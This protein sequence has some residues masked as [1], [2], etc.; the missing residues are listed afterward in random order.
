GVARA[1]RRR[2]SGS[3]RAAAHSFAASSAPGHCAWPGE[4]ARRIADLCRAEPFARP[5]EGPSESQHAAALRAFARGQ[6]QRRAL[7]FSGGPGPGNPSLSG[8][9]IT[10][11]AGDGSQ[12]G[13]ELHAGHFFV[14]Q[15]IGWVARSRPPVCHPK[16]EPRMKEH[17]FEDLSNLSMLDLFRIEAESQTGILTTSLLEIEKSPA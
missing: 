15:Q 3:R 9:R 14:A 6:L 1:V 10:R 4:R 2:I 13:A 11:S 17:N 16:P 8:G 7:C 12:S 5:R